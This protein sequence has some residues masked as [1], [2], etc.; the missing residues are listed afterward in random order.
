[1][2]DQKIKRWH[3]KPRES[4]G[5]HSKKVAYL[6]SPGAKVLNLGGT[7]RETF[8]TSLTA[9]PRVMAFVSRS[10]WLPH[11]VQTAWDKLIP[12]LIN[13]SFLFLR[14]CVRFIWNVPRKCNVTLNLVWHC[15]KCFSIRVAFGSCCHTQ[16]LDC[17]A[18]DSWTPWGLQ[19]RRHQNP[20]QRSCSKW[21][22][23]TAG[24]VNFRVEV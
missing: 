3:W 23:R 12:P 16:H 18:F 13:T 4:L 22:L 24:F 1:M 14:L 11:L 8:N 19:G 10:T 21:N 20:G 5:L 17:A 7:P 15:A 9:S 2:P 6:R